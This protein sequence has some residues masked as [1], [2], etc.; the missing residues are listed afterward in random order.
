M[1]LMREQG[2]THV[3]IAQIT[4]Y[5]RTY[6]SAMLSKLAAQPQMLQ[7]MSRGGRKLGSLRAL[8]AKEE[9]RAQVRAHEVVPGAGAELLEGGGVERG[10]VVH[11]GIEP[12]EAR[13]GLLH[14]AGQARQVQEIAPDDGRR[15]G[16]GRLEVGQQGIGLPAGPVAVHH[17]ASAGRVRRAHDRGPHAP[18]ASRHQNHR[19][20]HGAI[21][22]DNRRARSQAAPE[23][24][25]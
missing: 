6:V 7:G 10:G 2:K 11:Q 15:T 22:P 24:K 17:H 19:S 21:F 16:P 12:P 23:A 9:R 25:V 3:E 14:E 18:G 8:S 1:L 5:T 4:G 13:G 20:A